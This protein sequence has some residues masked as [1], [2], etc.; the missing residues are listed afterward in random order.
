MWFFFR[1]KRKD[2]TNAR[3]NINLSYNFKLIMLYKIDM[4]L[5]VNELLETIET[6]S[7]YVPLSHELCND[8]RHL[9]YYS[10]SKIVRHLVPQYV[11]YH[12]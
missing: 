3:I 1:K 12:K 11:K 5:K 4:F 6:D 7:G 10:V 8:I 9:L 2:L